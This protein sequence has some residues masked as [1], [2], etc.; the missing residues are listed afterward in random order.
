MI[1]NVMAMLS[2]SMCYE[3]QN[4]SP[5]SETKQEKNQYVSH[6]Y[7]WWRLSSF[8]SREYITIAW[9]FMITQ[10][11]RLFNLCHYW[12]RGRP[13]PHHTLFLIEFLYN[14]DVC[15]EVWRLNNN[16]K[17]HSLRLNTHILSTLSFPPL[18][19]RWPSGDQ[20]TVNTSSAWPGRSISIFLVAMDHTGD[21]DRPRWAQWPWRAILLTSLALGSLWCY[22]YCTSSLSYNRQTASMKTAFIKPSSFFIDFDDT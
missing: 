15:A 5:P 16:D 4:L 19:T 14:A 9:N 11:G 10:N 17:T 18:T 22:W 21:T 12:E 2:Q 20:S 6:F 3:G 8:V 13:P 1:Q 7:L